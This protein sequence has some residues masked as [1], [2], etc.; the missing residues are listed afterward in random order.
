MGAGV[1]YQQV[2]HSVDGAAERILYG[3][4]GRVSQPL[5]QRLEGH[6]KL[7][8]RQRLS[9]WAG[10]AR[11]ALAVRPRDTLIGNPALHRAGCNDL[12][13]GIAVLWRIVLFKSWRIDHQMQPELIPMYALQST[14]GVDSYVFH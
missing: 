11:C 5:R 9:L 14:D 3:Q 6:F 13:R 1:L 4:H 10:F 7:V 2:K 8:A 12:Q